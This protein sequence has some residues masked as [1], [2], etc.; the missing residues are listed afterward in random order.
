MSTSI[1]A[2]QD[3]IFTAKQFDDNDEIRYEYAL[4]AEKIGKIEEME[5]VLLDIIE[6]N[7]KFH[8]ALNALGYAWADRNVRLEEAKKLIQQAIELAPDDP[9]IAD[10][11]GWVEFRLG[12]LL[13]ARKVLQAAFDA[14]QDAEIAAH[15][16]EVMWAM[17]E[18]DQAMQVWRR[19]LKQDADNDTLRETLQ[20]LGVKP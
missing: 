11:L 3:V 2:I 15:L 1:D 4:A 18:R 20:R 7:P 6:Q 17:G 9:F 19:G 8:Q 14:R 12:R 13:E 5:S 10:S 16:G